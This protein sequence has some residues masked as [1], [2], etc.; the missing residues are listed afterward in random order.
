M[1][2]TDAVKLSELRSQ[3]LAVCRGD[4]VLCND[5][6]IGA[7]VGKITGGKGA[8]GAIDAVAGDLT[9]Q[10]LSAVRPKGQILVYGAM[11]GFNATIGVGDLLQSKVRTDSPK[12]LVDAL[13]RSWLTDACTADALTAVMTR[14]HKAFTQVECTQP[15]VVQC[16]CEVD[17]TQYSSAAALPP[18]I[19]L[20]PSKAGCACVVLCRF[21]ASMTT[22]AFLMSCRW[23]A[24]FI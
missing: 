19:K 14:H 7:E 10:M 4:E 20:P 13:P 12:A 23:F 1:L 18:Q 9:A 21:I 24:A 6:D 11:A 16:T 22:T 5:D 8:Y 17:N 15:V 2:P 3:L